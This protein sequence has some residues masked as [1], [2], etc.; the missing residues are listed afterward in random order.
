MRM[1]NSVYSS[2]FIVKSCGLL[3][4]FD[5]REIESLFDGCCIMNAKLLTVNCQ[6]ST[7]NYQ[8]YYIPH[9]VMVRP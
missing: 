7:I 2:N 9:T 8:L 5:S 4:F 6:L 1:A 3:S